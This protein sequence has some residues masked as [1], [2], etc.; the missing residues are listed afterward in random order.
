M[1][2]IYLDSEYKCHV[3]SDGT[4]RAVETDAFDGQCD[5][6]I[7]GYRFVPDGEVWIRS[8]GAVF[9]GIMMAPWKDYNVLDE[10]QR[11]YEQEQLADMRQ[12]LE[13]MGV[14]TNG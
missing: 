5:T 13:E 12:A 6:L 10:A 3:N 8:D 7:E 9:E 1:R 14:Y 11:E 4:M 2:T